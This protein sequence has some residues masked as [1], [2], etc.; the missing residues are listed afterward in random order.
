MSKLLGMLQPDATSEG[1]LVSTSTLPTTT[2]HLATT[3]AIIIPPTT[4]AEPSISTTVLPF[5]TAISTKPI[6]V[7]IA[8]V[9]VPYQTLPS[10][11]E[12]GFKYKHIK[13]PMKKVSNLPTLCQGDNSLYNE[14]V[15]N[16]ND[17]SPP[18]TELDIKGKSK[19]KYDFP[20]PI[21]DEGKLMGKL[22]T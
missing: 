17:E 12:R 11:L 9:L 19:M 21:P 3:S 20:M 4:T 7:T 22:F 15:P 1:E 18:T 2:I 5:S 8:P 14:F 16:F 10:S 13:V 6:H